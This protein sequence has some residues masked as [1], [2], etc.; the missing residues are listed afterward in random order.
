MKKLNK[1]PVLT[2]RMPLTYTPYAFVDAINLLNAH[3]NI[4]NY[5]AEVIE[6]QEKEIGIL[7]EMVEG[8]T[9]ETQ[10]HI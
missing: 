9:N 5:L 7:K 4:I 3:S 1:M 6:A 8:K 10:R 2:G